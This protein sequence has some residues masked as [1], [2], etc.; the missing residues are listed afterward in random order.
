MGCN[1]ITTTRCAVIGEHNLVASC[2]RI[3]SVSWPLRSWYR[4][5]ISL[6]VTVINQGKFAT[7][8]TFKKT[9]ITVLRSI[10]VFSKNEGQKLGGAALYNLEYAALQRK[11]RL[12]LRKEI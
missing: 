2:K 7:E 4:T 5:S 3:V 12:T 6:A 9:P 11:S 10:G 1:F 8:V